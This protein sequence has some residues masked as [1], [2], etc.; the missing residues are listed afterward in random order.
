METLQLKL[1]LKISL[2]SLV[3]SFK[4]VSFFNIAMFLINIADENAANKIIK[5]R[6]NFLLLIFCIF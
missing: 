4:S 2:V 3:V 6:K 5:L 1:Q